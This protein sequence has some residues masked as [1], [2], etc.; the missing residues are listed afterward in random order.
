MTA[1][2]RR[3]GGGTRTHTFERTQ[4]PKTCASTFPPLRQENKKV[5]L[6]TTDCSR[7][8]WLRRLLAGY[9]VKILV[10]LLVPVCQA[11]NF[12]QWTFESPPADAMGFMPD[13]AWLEN[14]RLGALQLFTC[15]AA[16]VSADG[17]AVTSASCLRPVVKRSI[18]DDYAVAGFLADTLENELQL[19]GVSAWQVVGLRDI[20]GI[21]DEE[22]SRELNLNY[23]ILP[24]ADSTRF[25]EYALRPYHDV[26]LVLLPEEAAAEFGAEDGVYPRFSA[27]FAFVRLYSAAGMPLET[28]SYFAWADRVPLTGEAVY[29]VAVPQVA[30]ILAAGVSESYAYN[31][32]VTPPFTTFYGMLDLYHGNGES[33]NWELPIRW[34][35]H[36]SS[37]D[38]SSPLNFAVSGPCMQ[39]GAPVF[40]RDLELLGV[41]FDD[42]AGAHCVAM[43]APGVLAVVRDIF[44]ADHILR[45]LEFQQRAATDE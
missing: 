11:Q 37:M 25:W 33:G 10:A 40:S 12:E 6:Q 41:A 2:Q 15:A 39:K 20:T 21:E 16:I 18:A 13:E 7:P 22:I 45:E 31:G 23:H 4:V 36:A 3:A 38:L 8:N 34:S 26:R 32:T 1:Q 35:T 17:L 44:R 42:V 30:P 9:A 19:S 29:Q 43:A 14:A 27:D 24:R 5:S 28:E